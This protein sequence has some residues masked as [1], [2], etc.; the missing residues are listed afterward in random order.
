MEMGRGVKSANSAEKGCV[1]YGAVCPSV[2]KKN[3]KNGGS[4][5]SAG[6]D[7]PGR[8]GLYTYELG[9]LLICTRDPGKGVTC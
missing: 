9:R 3:K 2:E 6:I 5:S 4:L 1:D 8:W 7:C